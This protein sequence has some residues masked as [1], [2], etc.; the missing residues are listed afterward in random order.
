MNENNVEMVETDAQ[1]ALVT[2]AADE[3]PVVRHARGR[4][5][6]NG[7]PPSEMTRLKMLWDELPE[8][9]KDYWREL[10][11]SDLAVEKIRERIRE[12]LDIHLGFDRQ[13][14]RFRDYVEQR[15]EIEAELVRAATETKVLREL[16]PGW[17]VDQIRDE[18][19]KRSYERVLCRG[20][21]AQGMHVLRAHTRLNRYLLDREKHEFNAVEL[22]RQQLPELK[23]IEDDDT[24]TEAEKT[25]AF[26]EKIFGKRPEKKI[27]KDEV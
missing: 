12:K 27:M 3:K 18:V 22:C 4:R 21:Y 26:M 20:D 8:D 10:F 17:S 19:I 14:S 11:W 23:V 15:D 13:F 25:Q 9:D 7:G 2:A 24:M 6:P 1:A 5:K 16:H